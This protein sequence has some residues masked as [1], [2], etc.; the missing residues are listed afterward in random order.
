VQITRLK[1]RMAR[2]GGLLIALWIVLTG[3][4]AIAAGNQAISIAL[5]A[6]SVTATGLS[7]GTTAVLFAVG[8]QPIPDAYMN[9][10][11]RWA[12]VADADRSGKV[13]FELSDDVPTIA[14]W[15]VADTRNGEIGI[16]TGD[17]FGIRPVPILRNTLRRSTASG[18]IDRF[19]FDRSYLALLYVHP[20]KGAWTWS[21]MDGGAGDTDGSNGSS[22]IDFAKARPL[23]AK[24]NA[25][26][27]VPG[28]LLVAIDY[29]NMEVAVIRVDATT[30]G[31]A[32]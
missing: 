2:A 24:S 28:G 20:G 6:R 9:R 29:M 32:R 26:Q 19:S 13:V 31:G 21:A 8:Q 30:I 7:P 5:G 14:I 27:I 12:V 10:V 17:R 25:P 23:I 11:Q 18:D 15:V 4:Q 16:S 3:S 1:R 22:T